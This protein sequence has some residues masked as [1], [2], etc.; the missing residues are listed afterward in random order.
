VFGLDAIARELASVAAGA[1]SDT[2][3]LERWGT[4][5]SGRGACSHPDGAVRMIRSAL[6]TFSAE[7]ALHARG[8]C[9]SK[10]DV[11]LLFV[12]GREAAGE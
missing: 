2:S 6:G 7:L 1:T 10:T 3:R 9:S 11:P 5:V 8:W 4:L 12:P